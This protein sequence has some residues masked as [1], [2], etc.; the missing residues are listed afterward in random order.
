LSPVTRVLADFPHLGQP[1]PTRTDEP[2]EAVSALIE[3]SNQ[4]G[5]ADNVACV[6][7]DLLSVE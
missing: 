6:V 7:A 4:A 2:S 5:G 3:L 1:P